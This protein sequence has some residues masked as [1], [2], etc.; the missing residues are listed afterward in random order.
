[1]YTY[2]WF[3]DY[4]NLEAAAKALFNS[5]YVIERVNEKKEYTWRISKCGIRIFNA[6]KDSNI[7]VEEK[8]GDE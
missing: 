2:L 5:G 8:T 4:G 1:M 6:N 7:V 3:D